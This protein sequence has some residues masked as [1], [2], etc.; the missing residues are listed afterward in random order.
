MNSL[1][2]DQ[3]SN[4]VI[5][6]MD[7]K[8][9]Y[10]NL[11]IERTAEVAFE[12]IE[13][14]EVQ[15]KGLDVLELSRYLAVNLTQVEVEKFGLS[16]VIMKR[17]C[18]GGRRPT[19]TGEEMKKHWKEETSLW[20]RP[21]RDPEEHEVRK[22]LAVAVMI[23]IKIVMGKNTFCIRGENYKQK[24]GGALGVSCFVNLQKLE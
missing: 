19:V 12:L 15:F 7:A 5:F 20:M 9:L 4:M 16:E 13:T 21:M 18:R 1:D 2:P 23:D 6:S 8:A 3:R 17:R 10:P 22:M 24:Q 11:Q 14:S